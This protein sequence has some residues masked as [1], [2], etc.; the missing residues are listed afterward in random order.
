MTQAAAAD[1]T[2]TE[3]QSLRSHSHKMMCIWRYRHLTALWAFSQQRWW[4][5]LQHEKCEFERGL[6][7]R[8]V[9]A[10]LGNTVQVPHD[11]WRLE[12]NKKKHTAITPL[13]LNPLTTTIVAPPSNASKWQMGFNSAFKGLRA[14][15]DT[16]YW[17]GSKIWFSRIYFRKF[18]TKEWHLF[19]PVQFQSCDFWRS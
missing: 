10:L 17:K 9:R 6:R 15:A 12:L 16:V 2:L 7:T 4:V 11:E 8:H 5:S 13:T 1:R 18:A 14:T 3:S 19:S